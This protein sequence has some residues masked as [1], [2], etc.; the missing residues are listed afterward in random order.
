MFR[1]YY[2]VLF[3]I[4]SSTAIA[5]CQHQ[6]VQVQVLGSGGPEL[7]DGRA[8][9][10]YL[11][12]LDNKGIVLIDTGS[13]SSLNYE[14]SGAKLVDLQLI[15]FTH[16]H[17]DHS[18]DFPAFIKAS[19]FTE[20]TQS[21]LV[22]GPEGNQLMPSASK[23]TD[24]LFGSNGAF[25]YL[26]DYLNKEA[27]SPFKIVTK[28]IALTKRS[29]KTVYTNNA[30]SLQAIPVH[31][32]PIPALAW[33][34]ELA[35]CAISF[36]GDMSNRYQTLAKLAQQADILIAHNAIPE[37]MQGAGRALHMPPSEI[38][39]IARQAGVK[40]LVLSHRMRRTLGKEQ[41]TSRII[42]QQYQGSLVFANDMDVFVP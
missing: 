33:R 5:V 4:C 3:F 8:S 26:S 24:K 12:W 42:K 34:V 28:N 15:A 27:D 29:P 25:P 6:R 10:S 21:L 16:F 41:E 30:I 32:G 39:Q 36:S 38:A 2:F 7:S 40:K 23:F 9:S 18:A 31:H 22:F 13:G 11:V 35:G 20:R 19:Y 37:A 17:V 1:L 14:K